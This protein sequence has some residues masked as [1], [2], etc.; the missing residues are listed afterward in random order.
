VLGSKSLDNLNVIGL[1][2][3][4]GENDVFGLNL[5]FFALKGLSHF[6]DSLGEERV[7]VGG[8]NNSLEGGLEINS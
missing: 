6:V 2:A 5:L 4:L 8:L 1:S 7:R 3:V